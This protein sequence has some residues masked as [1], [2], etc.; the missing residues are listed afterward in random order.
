MLIKRALTA[1]VLAP[2]AIAGILLLNETWFSSALGLILIIASWE[3]CRLVSIT[4]PANKAFFTIAI[5]ALAFVFSKNTALLAPLLFL[6]LTWWLVALYWVIKYPDS[7]ESL[8]KN[9]FIPVINGLFLFV[10]MATSLI[11]LQSQ[12]SSLL[13]FLLILIWATDVGAY[14]SGRQFGNK[15]LCPEVSPN[16]T[17]AGLYG[18]VVLA[19]AIAI[20]Y[21]FIVVLE[22]AAKDFLIFSILAI[23][24]SLVAVLGDLFESLLKRISG[25]KDSGNILPGHGGLL[26]RIDSLTSSA[27]IFLLFLVFVL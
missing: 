25:Y 9:I 19:Q 11:I 20:F 1:L 2:I 15:K 24:V 18:G 16:K 10:P 27:P 3:Y 5:L 22:P 21:V 13:L 26:D 6:A 12:N 8:K 7:H 17:L 23:V 14:F 4:S